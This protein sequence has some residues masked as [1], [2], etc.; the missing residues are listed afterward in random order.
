MNTENSEFTGATAPVSTTVVEHPGQVHM[1]TIPEPVLRS[2][3]MLG[4]Y[5][6]IHSSLFHASLG[7]LLTLIVSMVLEGSGSSSFG[8]MVTMAVSLFLAGVAFG[9]LYLRDYRRLRN[10]IQLYGITASAPR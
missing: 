7:G 8:I 3:E 10:T 5:Q 9:S 6:S 2:M 1:Y 4:G